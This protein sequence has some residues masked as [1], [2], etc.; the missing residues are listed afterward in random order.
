[1]FVFSLI[2]LHL[3][4]ELL[5]LGY[6][7]V[8]YFSNLIYFTEACNLLWILQCTNVSGDAKEE[9]ANEE[10][11]EVKSAKGKRSQKKAIETPA[12][13]EDEPQDTGEPTNKRR[14]KPAEDKGN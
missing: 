3:H 4:L 1:M 2:C 10:V 7:F 11:S 13:V 12:E 14:R 6:I 9:E 8:Q 5:S